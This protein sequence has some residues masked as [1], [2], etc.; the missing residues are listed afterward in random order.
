MTTTL[1]TYNG[2]KEERRLLSNRYLIADVI[3][4]GRIVN[5][6]IVL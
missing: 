3:K 1:F 5:G 4:Y 2:D 6:K